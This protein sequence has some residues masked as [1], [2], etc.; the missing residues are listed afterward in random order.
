MKLSERLIIACEEKAKLECE[1]R[2][3]KEICIEWQKSCNLRDQCIEDLLEDKKRIF[4]ERHKYF[5]ENI[6]LKSYNESAK[7]VFARCGA[8]LSENRELFAIADY[9]IK[10]LGLDTIADKQQKKDQRTKEEFQQEVK[11]ETL[12]DDILE[13]FK[14]SSNE[15]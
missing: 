4:D 2:R 15:I 11:G 6:D 10:D 12:K 14:Q 3:L 7:I 8:F 9:F 13:L 5:M 1:N